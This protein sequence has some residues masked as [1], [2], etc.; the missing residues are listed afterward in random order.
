MLSEC[1]D[2]SKITKELQ[3]IGTKE[4]KE[5]SEGNSGTLRLEQLNNG[6]I[7]WMPE[8]EEIYLYQI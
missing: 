3:T 5:T 8:H 4:P 7:P 6:L 1:K 2:T